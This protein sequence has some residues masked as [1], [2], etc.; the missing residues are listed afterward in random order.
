MN[1]DSLFGSN[2]VVPTLYLIGNGFDLAH[3]IESSY[4]DFR[5]FVSNSDDPFLVG[6]M[7]TFFSNKRDLW[8]DVET[9][10]GEYDENEIISYCT[11]D[12]D[13]DID[14]PLRSQ[15]ALEDGPDYLFNPVV[16][17]F[18]FKFND[19]VDSISLD[20]VIQCFRIPKDAVYIT[21]NY[22]E[23]LEDIYHIPED[24]ILH[25]HGYRKSEKSYVMGHCNPRNENSS[26]VEHD[27]FFIN[28][29]RAKIIRQMNEYVKPVASIIRENNTF[30]S[31]LSSIQQVIILGHS[32]NKVDYPYLEKVKDS[33]SPNAKWIFTFYSSS[34]KTSINDTI[35]SL[36]ITDYS[37]IPSDDPS[38]VLQ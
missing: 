32:L 11:P 13:F 24:H 12:S 9:A 27:L 31:G 20:G 26:Y 17:N 7:D 34:D 18:N 28:D 1:S 4:S 10:L 19:W 25:V 29:T 21:F 6:E 2:D 22:T 38:I 14:H 37:I 16:S 15:A 5:D 30:F 8:S 33:I 3:G 35:T 36:G 23:T